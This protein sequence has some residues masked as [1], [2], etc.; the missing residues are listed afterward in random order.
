VVFD[1]TRDV[2]YAATSTQIIAY[3]TNT[4]AELHRF[5]I[6]QNVS[7]GT[8]FGNG[9]MTVSDDGSLLFFSTSAGVRI[10][11]LGGFGPGGSPHV[12]GPHG[13]ASAPVGES[14][15]PT[16]STGLA[17]LV[18]VLASREQHRRGAVQLPG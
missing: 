14:G 8:P 2:L 4:W 13:P 3:D 9:E 5:D 10:Y 1:P 12:A 17:D 15:A 16:T 6:G 7:S 18:F 11:P